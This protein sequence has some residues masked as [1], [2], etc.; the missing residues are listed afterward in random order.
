M[1]LRVWS[2]VA[3]FIIVSATV[4]DICCLAAVSVKIR[5]I[6]IE[7]VVLVVSVC[8]SPPFIIILIIFRGYHTN[9]LECWVNH[10][11]VPSK[12]KYGSI[13]FAILTIQIS[14]L[15]LSL[16]VH[17]SCFQILQKLIHESLSAL[18]DADTVVKYRQAL[19]EIAP[20]LV[21]PS[22]LPFT[23]TCALLM[24]LFDQFIFSIS[25]LHL[26]TDSI[27]GLVNGTMV[28]LHVYMLKPRKNLHTRTQTNI[29]ASNESRTL[30][31]RAFAPSSYIVTAFHPPSEEEVDEG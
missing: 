30:L 15:V 11:N 17:F 25:S 31:T 23:N 12:F 18:G 9:S 2:T 22:I 29:Q 4:A 1:S 5:W 3:L 28:I 8:S 24:F 16:F 7:M 27:L 14:L 20:L 26:L 6:V 13:A 21:F 19:K 10:T